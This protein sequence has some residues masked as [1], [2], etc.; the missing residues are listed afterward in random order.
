MKIPL[1]HGN[2]KKKT[3]AAPAAKNGPKGRLPPIFF[4]LTAMLT[5]PTAAPTTKADMMAIKISGQPKRNPDGEGELHVAHAHA[6]AAR[7]EHEQLK[8]RESENHANDAC[9][10]DVLLEAKI[11]AKAPRKEKLGARG[12]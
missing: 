3:N 4:H 9:S 12:E 10:P 5:T 8:E 7:H 11:G 6:A 2:P 1:R